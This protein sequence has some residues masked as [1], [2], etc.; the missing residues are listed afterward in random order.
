MNILEIEKLSKNYKNFSLDNISFTV[1]EGC[2][3]GLIGENGAGKT[4]IINLVTG[5]SK[6]SGGNIKIFG[7]DSENLK[8]H[9]RVDIGVVLTGCGF[10]EEITVARAEKIL[11]G[12]YENWDSKTFFDYIGKFDLPLKKKIKTLSTGMKMRFEIAAALS[13]DAKLLILDEVTNGLDPAAR[14]EVLDMLLD[15]IQDEKRSVLISSHIVGDLEKICD[16]IT[17]IHKGE[18]VFSENKDDIL[19]KYAIINI[20][21]A[22]LKELDE[23]AVVSVQKTSCSQTAL[24]FKDR[25]PSGFESE[26]AS[27]E[28]IMV[29]YVKR[30]DR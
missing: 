4:T 10:P 21:D 1:P 25:I 30:G 26:K 7:K 2:I 6:K 18:L 22:Q 28:D 23:R 16:Y 11:S 24:V 12:I 3:M 13:H 14:M 19:E 9:E 29:Y 8:D 15:F 17:F 20:D 5:A 27:I